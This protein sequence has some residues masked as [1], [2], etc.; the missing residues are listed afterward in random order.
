MIGNRTIGIQLGVAR[1]FFVASD[2]PFAPVCFD[3]DLLRC[4]RES[5]HLTTSTA[6][7][8]NALHSTT[9]TGANLHIHVG[10]HLY[11]GS[12]SQLWPAWP[13]VTILPVRTSVVSVYRTWI[14]IN[15]LGED[16]MKLANVLKL[17]VS[18]AAAACS[19]AA[20]AAG[21]GYTFDSGTAGLSFSNNALSA[22]TTSGVS[23][24]AIA[25]ASYVQPNIALPTAAAGTSW[26]SSFNVS[27]I[28][29][30]GGLILTSSSVTGAQAKLTNL[31]LDVA[32]GSMYGDVTTSSWTNSTLGS[33]TGKTF[34]H[35]A[36]FKGT[37]S[38]IS[39]IAAGNGTVSLKLDDLFMVSS[40]IPVLGDALGVA[41]FLYNAIFP[42]LN[43]GNAHATTTFA[44]VPE[45]GTLALMGIGLLGV[46][47]GQ[48]ARKKQSQQSA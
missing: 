1:P 25:P 42:T 48:R 20:F 13:D 30:D 16:H 10:P 28:A 38:G 5:T 14:S 23:I 35:Q 27:T 43:F 18:A 24:T 11:V 39:N 41:P 44:P 9:A 37:E 32:T 19:A 36:L 47:G 46:A 7:M 45:P 17:S 31:S 34:T 8:L 2:R 21:P 3:F 29:M 6:S 22:L 15:P 33:Y 12:I 40:T 26:D 4:H